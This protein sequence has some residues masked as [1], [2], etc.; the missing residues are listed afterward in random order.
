[1]RDLPQ[2][3]VLS[4]V[5]PRQ[6]RPHRPPRALH[7]HHP[8]SSHRP[9]QHGDHDGAEHEPHLPDRRLAVR[10]DRSR[11]RP[12]GPSLQRLLDPP[13]AARPQE[14]PL[15]LRRAARAGPSRMST[16]TDAT[17]LKRSRASLVGGIA[18]GIGV[19]ILALLL[20]GDTTPL[21][22]AIAA[23]LGA[24]VATWVRLA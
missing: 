1:D 22:I 10:H 24:A 5:L 20:F 6:G 2:L 17:R 7:Q 19:A 12:P 23:A 8:P 4:L 11:S 13:P 15:D 16:T 9:S 18:T 21:H 3:R 14:A